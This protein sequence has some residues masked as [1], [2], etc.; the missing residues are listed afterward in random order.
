MQR[1]ESRNP[2]PIG[3]RSLVLARRCLACACQAADPDRPFPRRGRARPDGDR[4]GIRHVRSL[5]GEGLGRRHGPGRS[6][7]APRR[8]S[9]RS[10][11]PPTPSRA[12]HWLRLYDEEGATALRP[13]VVGTLPEIV[14]AEPNDDP[15]RPQ[16]LRR[17]GDTSTAG[18]PSRATWTDSRSR[19]VGARR[20]W[21]TWRRTATSARRWTPSCRSS[22]RPAS[23]W[24]RTTTS[25]AATRGSSS[26]RRPTGPMSSA[27]SPSPRLPTAASGS[28][29][30]TRSSTG[31]RLTTGG[32]LDHAFPLAVSRDGPC[33]TAA[34]GPNIPEAARLLTVPARRRARRA[35]SSLTRCWRGPPKS[36]ASECTAVERR[37]RRPGPS[38]GDP[39]PLH[40]QR[41][42]RPAGRPG[43]L[44]NHAQERR[45]TRLSC[46]VAGPR[47]A[48]RPGPPA[49]RRARER[50]WPSRTTS[51]GSATPSLP[52]P[53]PRTANTASSS[54]TSTV[55]AALAS[56][57]LLR[58][59]HPSP[60]SPSP[61]PPI[62]ST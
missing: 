50:R 59:L 32:F 49:D 14:E 7:P 17:L 18:S 10:A 60:I 39:G 19:S 44:S 11:S 47:L 13:F 51:A 43:R 46:R 16:R 34:V 29:A 1:A 61:S 38:P 37:A 35:P 57:Y 54:A 55:A 28:R 42:D 62:A 56:R 9:C 22:R 27:S 21:P 2:R 12:S 15:K 24:R 40:A 41:P 25:S 36:G 45:E 31:S 3:P 58:V 52:S 4:H 23:C 5:A 33:A 26:R 8:G 6:R 20:S 30:A 48:A 53:P